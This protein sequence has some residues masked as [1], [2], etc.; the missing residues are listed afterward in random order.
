MKYS[1]FLYIIAILAGPIHSAFGD[2][3]F[4]FDKFQVAT[5]GMLD[6]IEKARGG[7]DNVKINGDLMTPVWT[8]PDMYYYIGRYSSTDSSRHS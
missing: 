8:I 5:E 7:F 2:D 3:G 4:E 1:V 6:D